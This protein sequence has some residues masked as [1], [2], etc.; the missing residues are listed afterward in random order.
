MQTV[1]IDVS[2]YLAAKAA[3]NAKV[4]KL[5]G[6]VYYSRKAFNSITGVAEP[7]LLPLARE[8]IAGSLA[9]SQA[10]VDALTALL[11]D[12]DGAVEVLK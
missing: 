6:G 11:A 1:N 3:G 4:V 10:A 7:Q 8:G 12:F 2:D 5:N 9:Q